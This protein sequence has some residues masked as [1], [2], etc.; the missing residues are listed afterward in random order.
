MS[1]TLRDGQQ[2]WWA[3]VLEQLSCSTGKQPHSILAVV[4]IIRCKKFSAA[5]T[6]IHVFSLRGVVT[7]LS[8]V[9][10]VTMVSLL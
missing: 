8:A 7:R 5:C 3:G 6:I 9:S 10:S 4:A 1:V 2:A